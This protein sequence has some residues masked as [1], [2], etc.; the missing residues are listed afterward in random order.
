M[1]W[2]VDIDMSCIIKMIGDSLTNNMPVESVATMIVFDFLNV[3]MTDNVN[4]LIYDTYCE[5]YMTNTQYEQ[6]TPYSHRH[7]QPLQM[8]IKITIFSL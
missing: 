8:K 7:N 5:T 4:D 3:V 6:D 2:N 1:E